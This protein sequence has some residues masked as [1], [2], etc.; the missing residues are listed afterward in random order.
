MPSSSRRKKFLYFWT[1]LKLISTFVEPFNIFPILGSPRNKEK[2]NDNNQLSSHNYSDLSNFETLP[3]VDHIDSI[4]C[5]ITRLA[6]IKDALGESSQDFFSLISK[7]DLKKNVEYF[8][9]VLEN[10][11][12]DERKQVS[13]RLM[14]EDDVLSEV[15]PDAVPNE[16]RNW[17]SMTFTR[18]VS[19]MKKKAEDKPKFKSVA[20]AIRAGIMVDSRQLYLG[21][22]IFRFCKRWN[23]DTKIKHVVYPNFQT[24]YDRMKASLTCKKKQISKNFSWIFIYSLLITTTKDM[25]K[26]KKSKAFFYK[27]LSEVISS[28][29]CSVSKFKHVLFGCIA[30]QKYLNKKKACIY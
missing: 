17:L 11:L 10:V 21:K 15:E 7:K 28:H 24:C 14:S 18:S 22:N 30:F 5:S 26:F 3:L 19:N 23:L 29:K 4:K 16:V 12:L 20:Q 6:K 13:L 25:D 1:N 8:L 27:S 9:Q 2:L